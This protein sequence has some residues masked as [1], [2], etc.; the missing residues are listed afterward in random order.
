M[1]LAKY[2]S[3]RRSSFQNHSYTLPLCVRSGFGGND[4]LGEFGLWVVKSG[5]H[6]VP[7]EI[8]Y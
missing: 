2:Y 3:A 6:T 4:V 8:D 7:V 5:N 1:N